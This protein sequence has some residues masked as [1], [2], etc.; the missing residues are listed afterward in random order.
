MKNIMLI[1]SFEEM[2]V[3]V[4]L[5]VKLPTSRISF[6]RHAGVFVTEQSHRSVT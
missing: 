2:V 5:G 6:I 3:A 4:F 1:V